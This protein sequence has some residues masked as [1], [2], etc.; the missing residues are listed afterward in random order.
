MATKSSVNPI[1]MMSFNATGLTTSYK[2][3]NSDGFYYP[4]GLIRIINDSNKNILVSY[5]GATDHDYVQDGA[6]LQLPFQSNLALNSG[7]A[8][9]KKGTVVYIKSDAAGTGLIYL[10]GYYQ[11]NT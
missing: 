5:D 3:I 9:M 1:E 2:S 10:V 11:N 7:I 4:C 6:V 8:Q